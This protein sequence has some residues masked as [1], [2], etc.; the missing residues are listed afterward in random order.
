M[1]GRTPTSIG[2]L[3]PTMVTFA[4][5]M[6]AD[7][8]KQKTIRTY[9]EAAIWLAQRHPAESWA[10]ITKP[11]IREHMAWLLENY[12]PAYASNQYRALQAFFRW[13]ADEEEIANPMAG[14]KPPA[15]PQK[16][17]PVLGSGELERLL[18]TCKTKSFTD[19]RDRAIILM[20]ASSGARLAEITGMKTTD[21]DLEQTAAIVTGK[22]S[23]MRIVRLSAEAAVSLSRYLKARS[24]IAE[25]GPSL[26]IGQRGPLEPNGIYQMFVRRG[27]KAGVR[28]N[29]HRLR[30][31]FSHRWLV[32]GGNEGDLMQLNGW[33]SASMLN[34]YG[35]SAAA[36]RA[37]QHYDKVML[38]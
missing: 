25:A 16:L 36:E 27:K 35:A 9:S 23:K 17:V 19:L 33:S 5:S 6:R 21:I 15:V 22:N 24:K 29:P 31:D 14:M 10:G 37:R 3:G 11:Q 26:W 8:K 28:I 30:H 1:S 4:L 18:A 12:S 32:N 34:R 38:G 20:F 13:L 7:G 2:D